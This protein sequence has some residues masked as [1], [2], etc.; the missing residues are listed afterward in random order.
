M[1]RPNYLSEIK[2]LIANAKAGTVFVAVDFVNITDKKTVSMGLTRLETDGL[3]RRV[4]RGVY[5]KPEYS[6]LSGKAVSPCPDKVAKAIARSFGWTIV[7]SGDA[8]LYLL[9]LSTQVPETW[10]FVSDG[11]YK[12]YAYDNIT[13]QFKRT[14]NK[15]VS[16]AENSEEKN[17]NSET[18][19]KDEEIFQ[20]V[21][22]LIDN[23]MKTTP[24]P[25]FNNI[26]I[27]TVNRCNGTCSFCP[28]NKNQDPREYKKMPEEL[29]KKI[30]KELK[31]IN[32]NGA[33]A[34]HS[35]N[36]PLLDKKICN[37]AKY[38]RKELPNSYIY[39][40]TNGTLLTIDKFCEL[41]TNLD[42]LVIDNYND[43]IQ[44]IEPVKEIFN[45]CIQHPELKKKVRIDMRLQN[46]ILTSRGG[47]SDNRDEILTL[48]SSCLL[49]FNKI[50]VQPDGRIPLCCCDPFGKVI[51]GDLNTE[52]LVDIWNGKKARAL[53]ESL[54]KEQYSR[55]NL[56]LCSKCDVLVEKLDGI[57]YTDEDISNQW[58]NLYSIF[59]IQ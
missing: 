18:K 35:N 21:Y 58:K 37:Y 57:P 32:Y 16:K 39:L 51:L 4:L 41:I 3:I 25:L 30:I 49:P 20:D 2:R 10:V 9:G 12:K 55:K 6:G 54:Y 23:F 53:R 36:E 43:N 13:I 48:K 52:K 19:Q 27:E 40:Y 28:V 14:T 50:V 8:A 1:S 56:K 45:Y 24:T 42:L 34:L 17:Y 26:E 38:T 33:I 22:N 46:Q 15:E 29:F 31:E 7:P 47:Q 44:F 5:Y 59:N 11:T